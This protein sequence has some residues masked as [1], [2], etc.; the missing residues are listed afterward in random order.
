MF[1]RVR[2]KSFVHLPQVFDFFFQIMPNRGKHTTNNKKF[3]DHLSKQGKVREVH[4]QFF[5][6]S[7]TLEISKLHRFTSARD[8]CLTNQSSEE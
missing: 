4:M 5:R 2:L 6:R 7:V 3:R 1:R 8:V